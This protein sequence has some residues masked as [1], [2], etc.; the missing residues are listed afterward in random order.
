MSVKLMTRI[1]RVKEILKEMTEE[2]KLE[3]IRLCNINDNQKID[4]YFNKLSNNHHCPYCNSNKI[5][6][7]G[8]ALGEYPQFKCNNCGKNYST[9]TNTIFYYTHKSIKLW[10][11]YIE[12]FSQG[13]ALRKIVVEL[14]NKISLPTAFYWRHKI[15]KVLSN[16]NNNDTLNGIIEA[17]ETYI[18]E[19]QKGS[20]NIKGRVARKRGFS[21]EN[22]LVGL[23]HNKVCILTAIDRNK[24]TF[25]KPV[26]YG[27][28][29]KEDVEILQTRLQK[30]SILIT[31]GDKSYQVLN[32]VKLKQLKQGK[33]ENKIYHLNNINNYHSKFK[34]FMSRFN[35]VATKY[36]DFYVNYYQN[37]RQKLDLF[38]QLF[39]INSYYRICDIRN[40]RIC[41]ENPLTSI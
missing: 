6:K 21:S 16:N 4:D 27:K 11:K 32:N 35:G 5:K 17:D 9:K 1:D 30:D 39:Q 31:D 15:I 7:N 38:N 37:I 12:L 25:G 18:Q 29:S 36:L 13:L 8:K 24:T 14:D 26:C 34:Q 28:V 23:S 2:E 10:K 40:K 22:R 19:S 33:V 41:F 20:R 3:L